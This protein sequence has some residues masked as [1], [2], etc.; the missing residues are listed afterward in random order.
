[1]TS[2]RSLVLSAP[3]GTGKTLAAFAPVLGEL[4]SLPPVPS[5][6]CLYVTPLK[7]LGNDVRKNL[8][9]YLAGIRPFLPESRPLP[10]VVLR[11]GDTPAAARR[12]LWADP[13]DILL[14]TPE[15]LALLLTHDG[16]ADLFG[17]LRWVV[18]DE[19]HALAAGKRGADR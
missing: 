3:T 14:T 15:T 6:R 16:A 13:P 19:V 10:R 5:V 1:I 7:A 18:V 17:G 8:R 12:R 9:S 11:T 2:G 4:L